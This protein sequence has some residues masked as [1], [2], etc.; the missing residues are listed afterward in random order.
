MT[1]SSV[2]LGPLDTAVD[3]RWQPGGRS[4]WTTRKPGQSATPGWG[5][6]LVVN[7]GDGRV[8]LEWDGSVVTA[9][10]QAGNV[11]DAN[12]YLAP[13]SVLNTATEDD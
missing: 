7:G 10:R 4:R 9:A 8:D 6:L 13:T 5:E 11:V 2:T 1:S 12:G 3:P